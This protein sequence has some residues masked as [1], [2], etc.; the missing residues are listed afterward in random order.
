MTIEEM[1]ERKR[2][3]GY[4]NEQISDWAHVPLSTVQKVFSGATQ[5]PRYET[6]R[7]I[8]RV[9][10]DRSAEASLT[11]REATIEYGRPV[12]K[13]QGEYTVADY[14]AWPEDERIEL[15]DGVIYDMGAPYLIHQGLVSELSYAL[16][17]YIRQKNG[18]CK[19]FEAP[20]DVQLNCDNKTMLQPDVMVI[21]NH[22]RMTSKNVQGSPDLVIEVLSDGTRK[23]DMTIKL[24][25]YVSAGVREYWIVDP[26]KEKILVYDIENDLSVAIYGFTDMVPVKIF[27]DECQ[28]DFKEISAY[29]ED[30]PRK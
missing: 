18:K 13:R 16:K 23:K 29:L 22:D 21:C 9:L 14:Y 8:E 26:D 20:V 15:I 1:K 7:A 25:K 12:A 17:S 2:Q 4:T 5:A 6:L 3:L 10:T 24:N 30:V 19:V 11:V 28:I 27:G